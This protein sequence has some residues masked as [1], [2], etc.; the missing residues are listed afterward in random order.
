MSQEKKWPN[1]SAYYRAVSNRPPRET[2]VEALALFDAEV[3]P[4][5]RFAI[6]LGC[7]IGSDTF[8][9][10]RRG[11]RVLAIDGEQE[12]IEQ[13]RLGVPPDATGRLEAQVTTFEA[14]A[15]AEL[16]AADLVNASFSLP[17]CPPPVFDRLWGRIVAALRPGGRFAGHLFGPNDSW[18][19]RP[20][21]NFHSRAQVERLLDGFEVEQLREMDEDGATATG[22]AKHWHVFW[23]VARKRGQ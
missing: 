14:F 16:P 3:S 10:L 8:E 13:V 12:A 18:A 20:E 19:V 2:L 11:W 4:R 5:E 21:M 7:G 6:D 15:E 9:L 17:F 22:E 1:W 23:I